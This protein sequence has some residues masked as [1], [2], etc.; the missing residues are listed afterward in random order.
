MTVCPFI[1]VPFSSLASHTI[2]LF[3][4]DFLFYLMNYLEERVGDGGKELCYD[5]DVAGTQRNRIE[6]Q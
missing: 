1:S 6:S 2:S 4:E 5:I 3:Y